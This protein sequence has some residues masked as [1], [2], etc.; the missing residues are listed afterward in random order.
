MTPTLTYRK[1]DT[2]PAPVLV[3][4]G[5][6]AAPGYV[7]A[8]RADELADWLYRSSQAGVAAALRAQGAP[9]EADVLTVGSRVVAR[10]GDAA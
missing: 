8:L 5:A 7:V 1:A 4:D 6:E 3:I 10:L 2:D 9:L